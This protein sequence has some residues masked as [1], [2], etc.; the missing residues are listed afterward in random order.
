MELIKNYKL[1]KNNDG[2]DLIIYFEKGSLDVE[3]L[4]PDSRRHL[5]GVVLLW[6]GCWR[7]NTL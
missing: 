2:Y 7:V 6:T 3:L 4:L 5:P 1:V